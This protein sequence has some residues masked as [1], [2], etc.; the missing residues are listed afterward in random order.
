MRILNKGLLIENGW[1]ERNRLARRIALEALEKVLSRA[2][3]KAAVRSCMSVEKSRLVICQKRFRLLQSGRL[4][5]IGGGK[6]GGGMAEA[7]EEVA[8]EMIE[9]GVVNIPLGVKERY[10][11]ER[12]ELIEA[13]HPTPDEA[14]VEGCRRM[15]EIA[16]RACEK[17]IVLV[18]L[19]GGASSLLPCP[20]KGVGL[21]ELRELTLALLRAG[22]SIQELNAVRKHVSQVKGGRLAEACYPATVIALIISDVVGDRLDV[23]GSGPTAPDSSSYGDAL[24]VLERYGLSKRFPG[25]RGHL[26]RGARGEL[27][28]T[29]KEGSP[30]FKK[31]H[32]FLVSTNRSVLTG[33]AGE[34]GEGFEVSI[35]REELTGE[36]RRAGERLATML[37]RERRSAKPQV[38]LCGG[39]TT[40]TVRGGGAGGRN[41]ELV[42]GALTRLRGEGIAIAGMGTD[43]VDGPT[44]AAGAIAD[45][46]SLKRALEK[47]LSPERF[48][49]ENDSY[50]FFKA[51]GDL[52]YTGQT[53]TNVND[54]CVMVLC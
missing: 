53:G 51:L 13:S 39:E 24:S 54:V 33:A 10:S 20:M 1:G 7:V 12:V 14:G 47:G 46:G 4:F 22:A 11:A 44:D 52:I 31:V 18:L 45:G 2:D 37:M 34:L 49:R 3:P 48:L 6:A 21:A 40:V 27:P 30:V 5:V 42:L 8:G 38:L 50:H 32:N 43:G 29:L 35:L 19:S 9:E 26:E 41:Q 23:I 16:E 15:L 25:I 17:D 28:E 36:A